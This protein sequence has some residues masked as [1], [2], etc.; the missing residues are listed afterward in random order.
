[1]VRG[2]KMAGIEWGFLILS[3][4]R[5]FFAASVDVVILVHKKKYFY[6]NYFRQII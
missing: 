5:E 3:D 4:F 2:V 6:I 1:M